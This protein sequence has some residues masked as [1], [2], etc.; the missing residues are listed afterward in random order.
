[1]VSLCI[2]V[3]QGLAMKFM[4]QRDVEQRTDVHRGPVAEIEL[5]RPEKKY[6]LT[7]EMYDAMSVA[8]DR[9]EWATAST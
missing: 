9:A 1:M 6:A 4:E 3:G 8:F 2:G 7:G 5:H